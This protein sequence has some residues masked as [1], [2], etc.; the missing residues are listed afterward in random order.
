MFACR[1]VPP[2]PMISCLIG[3]LTLIVLTASSRRGWAATHSG[4]GITFTMPLFMPY[5]FIL[6]ILLSVSTCARG[7]WGRRGCGVGNE[8]NL[9]KLERSELSHIRFEDRDPSRI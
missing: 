9:L 8:G 4:G 3:S 7:F 2:V 5:L 1:Y 6:S